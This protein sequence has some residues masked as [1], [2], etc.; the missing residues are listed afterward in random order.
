MWIWLA[1]LLKPDN[2]IVTYHFCQLCPNSQ[3]YGVRTLMKTVLLAENTTKAGAERL[4]D[5]YRKGFQVIL[6]LDRTFYM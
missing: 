3:T 2:Q 4:E 5:I 6:Y 1:E